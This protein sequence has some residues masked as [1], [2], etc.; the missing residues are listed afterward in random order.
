[1]IEFINFVI[2]IHKFYCEKTE[3]DESLNNKCIENCKSIWRKICTRA[4]KKI[5]FEA[6]V[7][8]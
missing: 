4:L 6:V 3:K 7:K 8:K 5:Q 2:D 1:M